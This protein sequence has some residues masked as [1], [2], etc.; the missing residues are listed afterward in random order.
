MWWFPRNFAKIISIKINSKC[1]KIEKEIAHQNLQH[2]AG[3]FALHVDVVDLDDLVTHVDQPGSIG[4]PAVHNSRDDDLAR[5]LIG[6][7]CGA[8]ENWKY[9]VVDLSLIPKQNSTMIFWIN[10]GFLSRFKLR[11]KDEVWV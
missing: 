3:R 9:V 4:R 6:F 5:F 7:D 11:T 8:L 2:I 1:S 10:V